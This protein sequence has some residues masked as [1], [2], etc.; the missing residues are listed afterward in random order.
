M[1]FLFFEIKNVNMNK[2]SR[3]TFPGKY[4]QKKHFPGI[5][6]SEKDFQYSIFY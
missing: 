4:F 1:N 5:Y 3:K 2:K 6:F